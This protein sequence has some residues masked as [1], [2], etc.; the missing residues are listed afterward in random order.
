MTNLPERRKASKKHLDGMVSDE[1]KMRSKIRTIMPA[2]PLG[3]N[4]SSSITPNL[5][6]ENREHGQIGQLCAIL[7]CKH[8]RFLDFQTLENIH[9]L[10]VL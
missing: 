6:L 2:N 4:I 8:R 3:D 10:H 7:S 5:Y 1:E 9:A